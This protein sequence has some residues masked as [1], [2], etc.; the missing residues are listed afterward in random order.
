M[1]KLEELLQGVKIEWMPLEMI[2]DYE[3][4]TKYLVKTK[5]YNDTYNTPVLTAGK[6]FILGYTD[7]KDGIN[8]AS[9]NPVI[10]FD[11][12]TTSNKWVDF[13]FKAKSSAMKIIK[14]KNESKG[15]LRYIYYWINTLPSDLVDGDHKRQWIS[16]FSKKIIPLPPIEIQQEIVRILDQLTETTNNLKTELENERLI[17]KKQFEYYLNTLLCFDDINVVYKSLEEVIVSLKTGL[18]PRKNFI[19]NSDNAEGFYVTVREIV[20]GE[21]IFFNKTDRVSNEAI[22][23]INNRS[24]LE[25]GDVLFT[26]TGT[27]G[28]VA[29]IKEDPINWNIKEGVYTIKP[30]TE[31]INSYY[32]AYLLQSQNIKAIYNKKIVGSPVVSLPMKDLRK[33]SIPIPPLEE[34]ERIVN[35][36]DQFNTAHTAIEEEITKEIKLRTQ[37]YEYYRE[38]LLTFPKN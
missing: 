13:D 28:R 1:S 18:N 2:A 30:K 23:I 24:N 25:K 32:L 7:E 14:S 3:Q 37:Q 34:Q 4:P 21:I 29:V 38:K 11:D 31:I 36:L 5:D 15:L 33:I 10:I 8:K 6:T 9:E 27:V 20:C 22:R 12:F 26:G 35:L 19:L 17:R 16:N